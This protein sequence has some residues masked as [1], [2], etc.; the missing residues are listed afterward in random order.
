MIDELRVNGDRLW[1]SLMEMAKIGATEKGGVCR[2]ALTDLDRESRDLLTEW[3]KQEGCTRLVDPM[4][5]M[6][7]SSTGEVVNQ[8]I[9]RIGK[10]PGYSADRWEI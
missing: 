8:Q 4:G 7:F 10:S 5:N 6:F 9:G 3:A 1:E 2:L